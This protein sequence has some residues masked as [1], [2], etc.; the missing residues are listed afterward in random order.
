MN[1]RRATKHRMPLLNCF[2]FNRLEQHKNNIDWDF[3]VK[4]TQ[5]LIGDLFHV[6]YYSVLVHLFLDTVRDMSLSVCKTRV[7]P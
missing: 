3:L 4:T 2:L 6:S 1:K 5:T 7:I